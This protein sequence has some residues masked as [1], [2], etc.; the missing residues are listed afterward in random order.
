MFSVFSES[1]QAWTE[2]LLG[3]FS[4]E[5]S[6]LGS[7]KTDEGPLWVRYSFWRYNKSL[8]CTKSVVYIPHDDFIT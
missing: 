6:L 1:V 8:Q 3:L 4:F 2:L 7:V 5:I